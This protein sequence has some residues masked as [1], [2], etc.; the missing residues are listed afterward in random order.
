MGIKRCPS[1]GSVK[2]L[3]KKIVGTQVESMENGEFKI[4]SEGRNFHLEI[5]G[6]AHCKG[7]F[8]DADLVESVQCKK[9]GKFVLP[10]NLDANGECD[11][12]GALMSRPELAE[13]SKEDIIRMMLKLEKATQNNVE[14]TVQPSTPVVSTPVAE[15][16]VPT[17]SVVE[18]KMKLAQEA[19]INASNY[20]EPVDASV[21]VGEIEETVETSE[22]TI[23]GET[24]RRGRPR[25]KTVE[26]S[27]ELTPEQTEESVDTVSGSQEAPFPEKDPELNDAFSMPVPE[28]QPVQQSTAQFAMF[29]EEQSF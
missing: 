11:I 28:E 17:S 15:S 13:M 16:V 18:E 8:T 7:N 21:P 2:L 23:D 29:D 1:C 9:C 10:Q 6:C 26:D 24:K 22:S 4:I 3:A 25:K 12:C 20:A 14:A 19:I 27:A 5:V